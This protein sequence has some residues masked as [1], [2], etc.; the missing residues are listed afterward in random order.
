MVAL[1]AAYGR[2]ETVEALKGWYTDFETIHPFQDGNG[3]V[4]GVIV[5]AWSHMLEPDRGYLATPN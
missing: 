5:A 2:P 4:G 1:E 3:R